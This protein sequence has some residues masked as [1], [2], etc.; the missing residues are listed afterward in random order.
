[1]VIY[2]LKNRWTEPFIGMFDGQT[3]TVTEELKVPDYVA[4]HIKKQSVIRDNPVTAQNDYQL[5]I[6]ELGDPVT[7]ISEKPQES[8]DRSDMDEFRKVVLRPSGIRSN[9]PGS[10]VP[11]TTTTTE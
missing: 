11:R 4:I 5:G 2:T 8:L 3:Y 7:P 6:V 1:M 9:A 10:R